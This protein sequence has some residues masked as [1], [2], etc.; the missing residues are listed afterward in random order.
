[1]NSKP[2]MTDTRS[3]CQPA[4][5]HEPANAA[6]QPTERK[7]TE[8]QLASS[9]RFLDVLINAVPNPIFVKDSDHR[10]VLMNEAFCRMMGHTREALM[11]RLVVA[12]VNF[13][14]KRIAGFPSE[15]LVL[16]ALDDEKG[17]V[18]LQPDDDVELGSRIA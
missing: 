3:S 15:I 17:V 18:L 8:L 12:V 16:G 11:G 5:Y 6:L 7:N 2:V 1:M 4:F 13:P 10:W 9:Q 14:P